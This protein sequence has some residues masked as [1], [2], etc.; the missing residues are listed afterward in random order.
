MVAGPDKS[1]VRLEKLKIRRYYRDAVRA[2]PEKWRKSPGKGGH[3]E[4]NRWRIYSGWVSQ[5]RKELL[6]DNFADIWKRH[7]E[8]GFI[9]KCDGSEESKI[10]LRDAKRSYFFSATVFLGF[11]FM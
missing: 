8:V 11:K 3:T 7:E 2:S 1:L 4:A 6:A 10:I 5:A 9:D